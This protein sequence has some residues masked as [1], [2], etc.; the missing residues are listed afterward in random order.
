MHLPKFK[1]FPYHI[2]G[3]ILFFLMHGYSEYIGLIPFKDLLILFLWLLLAAGL[4]FLFFR[5]RLRS[6]TKSG[7]FTTFMLGFY[8]FFG[9]VSDS[10]KETSFLSP[11]SHYR[12]L[13]GGFILI[14]I[15]LFFYFR[16]SASEFQ[17]LTFYLNTVFTIFIA[18]DL[19]FI[20]L[21]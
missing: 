8:L 7:L 6:V 5:W 17:K 16:R 12:Y 19:F 10:F 13:L 1:S 18:Y 9:A 14:T 2:I 3:I 21:H 20:V 15:F 11:L 4:I